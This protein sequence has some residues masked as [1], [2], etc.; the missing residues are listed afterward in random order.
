MTTESI[1]EQIFANVQTTLEAIV[2][3]DN[4]WYTP[5][6]VTRCDQFTPDLL[7]NEYRVIYLIRDTSE[8]VLVPASRDF[9][10][11]ARELTIFI[12]AAYRDERADQNAHTMKTPTRG[13]IRHRLIR[14]ITRAL[15]QDGT[16]GALAIDTEVLDPTKDFQDIG[17][18]PWILAEVPV[19]ILYRHGYD[20][21]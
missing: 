7:R 14:D 4:Y 3:G 6:I 20:T 10:N 17:S 5:A 15:Y 9:G 11:D 16:R 2:A 8:L 13:T 19:A 1:E 18:M 21:P 12:L